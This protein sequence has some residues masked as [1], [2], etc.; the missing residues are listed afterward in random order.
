MKDG[1]IK[2]H[3]RLLDNPRVTDPEW[4]SVWVYLLLSATY[5]PRKMNFDGKIVVLQPGQL[6]TGRHAIANAT[7]VSSAKV[8]RVLETLKIEQ[9]IEQQAGIKGSM[10]T[11]LKW[12]DYQETEQQ[13]EH[14]LSSNRAATE[15]R[16]STNKKEI[17]EEIKEQKNRKHIHV[18]CAK[19][20]LSEVEVYAGEI[21][22]PVTEAARFIDYYTGNGWMVGRNR[23]KDWRATLRNWKRTYEEKSHGNNPTQNRSGRITGTPGKYANTSTNIG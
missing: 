16:L 10:F 11:V 17:T 21:G 15:Q 5:Q 14:G 9:Q 12:K 1:W 13:T 2:L 22:L 7:G 8:Y 23:M 18:P 4:L 19:P 3:R 6:I 20:E